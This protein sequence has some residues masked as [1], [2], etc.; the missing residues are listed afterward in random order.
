L[1]LQLCTHEVDPNFTTLIPWRKFDNVFV[2]QNSQNGDCHALRLE[3]MIFHR[4][5]FICF[6]KP[7][8]A[9]LVAH[10]YEGKMAR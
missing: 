6:L 8:L 7:N 1:K 9:E 5:K 3:H 2:G 4:Y 10:N